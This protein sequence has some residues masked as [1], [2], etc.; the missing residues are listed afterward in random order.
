MPRPTRL[1]LEPRLRVA[2]GACLKALREWIEPKLTQRAAAAQLGV[3]P[4]TL[5]QIEK[6]NAEPSLGLI[7]HAARLYQVHPNVILG[8]VYMQ[9]FE[10]EHNLIAEAAGVV[11][12]EDVLRV[13]DR[14]RARELLERLGYEPIP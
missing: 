14:V 8:V 10:L 9:E 12:V 2:L 5:S 1:L 6:G 13:G 4:A 7:H 11:R 3:S